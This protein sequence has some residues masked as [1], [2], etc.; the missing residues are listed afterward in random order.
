M[1]PPNDL[2]RSKWVPEGAL[3]TT[4]FDC[5]AA[6]AC[7]DDMHCTSV[8]EGSS[9]RLTK[10]CG[11]GQRCNPTEGNVC[12]LEREGTSCRS[13]LDCSKSSECLSG[14]CIYQ[15]GHLV[16]SELARRAEE[17]WQLSSEW[18]ARVDITIKQ[19]LKAIAAQKQNNTHDMELAQK[20]RMLQDELDKL[21]QGSV[22]LQREVDRRSKAMLSAS[23]VEGGASGCALCIAEQDIQKLV[24]EVERLRRELIRCQKSPAAYVPSC[25]QDLKFQINKYKEE[26]WRRR[27]LLDEEVRQLHEEELRLQKYLTACR[28]R[29][30]GCDE[31]TEHRT[32]LQIMKAQDQ[33]YRRKKKK[34]RDEQLTV[35]KCLW[36]YR[37][38]TGAEPISKVFAVSIDNGCS[39]VKVSPENK[40]LVDCLCADYKNEKAVRDEAIKRVAEANTIWKQATKEQH[41]EQEREQRARDDAHEEAEG[42]AKELLFQQLKKSKDWEQK[43]AQLMEENKNAVSQAK[44]K[45]HQSMS[46][47]HRAEDQSENQIDLSKLDECVAPI[48]EVSVRDNIKSSFTEGPARNGCTL[49]SMAKNPLIQTA[50]KC[51]CED[52]GH[53]K[54]KGAKR[55]S[56]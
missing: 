54:D 13:S 6:Q 32:L 40:P 48:H 46:S 47:R 30:S 34:Q 15:F 29:P 4:D 31:S 20:V 5:G 12:R 55:L 41:A 50:Y 25:Q 17:D 3:C 39:N 45:V 24:D 19:T 9:C 1:L 49:L 7:G 42:V 16:G 27:A 18:R 35:L 37:K 52:V 11:N 44:E 36:Q 33:L 26:I 56:S 23:D 28:A 10:N 38:L 51:L 21:K 22:V 53:Q 14:S 8:V 2:L 43:L